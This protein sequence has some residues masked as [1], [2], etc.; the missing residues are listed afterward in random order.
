MGGRNVTVDMLRGIAMLLVVLVHTMSGTLS[1]FGDSWVFQA[2]W[3]LQIPLFVAVSGYVTR[4]RKP[5]GGAC[6]MFSLI[7]R[8]TLSYLL[9]WIVWTFLIRGLLF[10]AKNFLDLGYLLYHMDVGYW[11]L[12]MLWVICILDTFASYVSELLPPERK[13]GRLALR[14][15]MML[16][17]MVVLLGIGHFTGLEFFGIKYVLYYIPFFILGYLF[18]QCSEMAPKTKALDIATYAVT[19]F[20]AI[21]WIAMICRFDF[22]S[23]GDGLGSMVIRMLTS[24]LGC[25]VVAF[26]ASLHREGGIVTG[27]LA[28][29]GRHSLEI[30]LIH[31][32]CLNLIRPATMPSANTFAGAGLVAV[33]FI[34]TLCIT[35]AATFLLRYKK[36]VGKVL[37][38]R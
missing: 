24:V 34:V 32:L 18:G 2:A 12:P 30:Y 19:A 35:I 31:D 33:N 6:G 15:C 36:A 5:L 16:C 4:Y 26:L 28:W 27:A 37:F 10:G 29:V 17:G 11:F 25:I 14:V 1:D 20:S 22:Y 38:Y 7:W 13:T 23:A 3:T 8:R 9:P 21:V